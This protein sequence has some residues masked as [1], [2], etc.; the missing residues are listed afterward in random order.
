MQWPC[1]E[2]SV[3]VFCFCYCRFPAGENI[4]NTAIHPMLQFVKLCKAFS[5]WRAVAC[6]KHIRYKHKT[7]VEPLHKE[8]SLGEFLNKWFCVYFGLSCVGML[9]FHCFFFPS[10]FFLMFS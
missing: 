6:P 10:E 8:V 5:S 4:S 9:L 2:N 1:M 3:T 7:T